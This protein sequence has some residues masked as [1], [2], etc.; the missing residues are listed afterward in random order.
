MPHPSVLL[1]A[2]EKFAAAAAALVDEAYATSMSNGEIGQV[3][4][5]FRVAVSSCTSC[6]FEQRIFPH[7][8][9]TLLRRK[10]RKQPECFLACRR[11][12]LFLGLSDTET[13]CPECG[14]QVNPKERYTPGRKATCPECGAVERLS[15]R[16][17][18][19]GVRWDPVLVEKAREKT[20]EI[21]MPSA[22]DLDLASPERWRPSRTLGEIR[23]GRETAVLLR[24]GF[25]TWDDIYP[26]RQREVMERLL[27]IAESLTGE[28]RVDRLLQGAVIGVAEMAGH[29][30]RWDRWYLKSYESM[31]GHRF[32]FV[33][34]VAEPN[35]W[36]TVA[37]GRG[38][39]RR[40]LR[41]LVRSAKWLF[42]RLEAPL[43]VERLETLGTPS[44]TD[45]RVDVRLV[46]GSSEALVLPARCVDLVLTD[47]PYHDDVQYDE[48][49]LPLR[50]WANLDVA[51]LDREAVA[52]RYGDGT[53]PA[54]RDVLSRTMREAARVL[55]PNGHLILSYANREPEAW[56]DLFA[57]LR[58]SGLAPVG[59][60]AVH[61]ENETDKAKRNV[62]A[63]TKDLLLELVKGKPAAL[64]AP[65]LGTSDEE[66]FLQL[67]GQEF[68]KIGDSPS[69]GWEAR[70]T[71]RLSSTE[72]AS[73]VKKNRPELLGTNNQ[74]GAPSSS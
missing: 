23:S 51:K 14:L 17:Q 74:S 7:A 65:L 28:P 5:T 34:F 67:V 20:R 69:D 68:L 10:E 30:S 19:S 9:L 36:G 63:C 58:A 1:A 73:R 16:F 56:C 22:E 59:F 3:A 45:Q 33:T 43:E 47:P 35:V 61:S 32:N 70:L 27:E 40:R 6:G 44:S 64:F 29:L 13:A 38:T 15:E 41:L 46:E 50:A 24:H 26:S 72:F 62:R 2:S 12:H 60:Q 25:E 57:A 4:H 54:F 71:D 39:V 48:L 21:V 42:E 49:S 18:S 31:A 53:G 66:Q 8:L 37:S 11:G 55:R 52:G